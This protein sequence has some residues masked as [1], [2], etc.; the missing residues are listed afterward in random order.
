[1]Y[2]D[3]GV[4]PFSNET[5]RNTEI[6]APQREADNRLCLFTVSRFTLLGNVPAKQIETLFL[7]NRLKAF[8][9]PSGPLK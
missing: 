8:F 2:I 7:C 3:P 1:M 5:D 6:V 9:L 4:P